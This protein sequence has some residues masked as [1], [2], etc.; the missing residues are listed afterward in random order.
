MLRRRHGSQPPDLDDELDLLVRTN[1]DYLNQVR[2]GRLIQR[3]EDD[4]PVDVSTERIG[5][6]RDRV[7][8][9]LDDGLLCRLKLFWPLRSPISAIESVRWDDELSWVI[10]ARTADGERRPLYAWLI[11]LTPATTARQC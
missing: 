11:Q 9:R 7:H 2:I 3:L 5:R 6:F 8:L 10:I 1:A 4:G